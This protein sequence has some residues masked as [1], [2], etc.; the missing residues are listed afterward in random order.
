MARD[1]F[2]ICSN[3]VTFSVSL[4]GLCIDSY[5]EFSQGAPK[6]LKTY[7]FLTFLIYLLDRDSQKSREKEEVKRETRP[8][9][10]HLAKH[11]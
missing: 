10:V 1:C 7:F 2:T 5:S 8:G 3:L 6:S 9:V 4:V 11:T